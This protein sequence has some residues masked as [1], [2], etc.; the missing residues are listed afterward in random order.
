MPQCC[1]KC[2]RR[3]DDPVAARRADLAGVR[4]DGHATRQSLEDFVVER[5]GLNLF[6]ER[7][8]GGHFVWP[9]TATGTVAMSSAELS[10]LL[11]GID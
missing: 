8:D 1:G 3:L 9:Q 4:R 6:A 11:E 7:L 10:M 5:G 2:W